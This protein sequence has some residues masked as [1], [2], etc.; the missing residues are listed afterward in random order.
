MEFHR[1]ADD[2]PG[3]LAQHIDRCAHL[4]R[5]LYYLA[6]QY[7]VRLGACAGLLVAL[8]APANAQ[9]T[10]DP[11]ITFVANTTI[12]S[13]Q[14]N[15]N[16]A[17]LYANFADALNRTGG[18]MTG[19]LL[20]NADNTLDLGSAALSWNDIWIDGTAT[21]ATMSVTTL[22]CT[23]CVGATQLASTTVTAAAYGSASGVGTF[24][25]DADGRLTAAST[26]AIAIAA[27]QITSGNY[28]ATLTA[29]SGV[30]VGTGTGTGSTPAVSLTALTADWTQS[31][32]YDIV[33]SNASAEI[34]IKESTGDTYYGILEVG[35]LSA[36]DATYTFSG[37]SGTVYTSANDPFDTS[38]EIQSVAVG[39]DA[40]GTVGNIAVAND[41][42]THDAGNLTGTTLA[43][44]VVSTSITSTGTISSGT[45]SASFGNASV[46]AVAGGTYTGDDSIATVGTITTGTWNAG[47][48]TSSGALTSSLASGTALSITN[49]SVYANATNNMLL[50][51][52]DTAP[53][54]GISLYV[55]Q[56]GVSDAVKYA[57]YFSNTSTNL[58]SNN[59]RYGIYVAST[60][61]TS[62]D[63]TA[64]GIY[65]TASGGTTANWAG[66]F[67]GNVTITG[68][69]NAVGTITSG[70]WNAGAVTSSGT[71]AGVS[72]TASG[73]MGLAATG[74]LYLDGV[75]MTGNTYI[76]EASAD[77]V[78]LVT[79][80]AIHLFTS[81][82]FAAA[83]YPTTA[84]PANV[85]LAGDGNYIT[86]VTSL[87]AAKDVIGPI[88]TEEARRVVMALSGV[89]YRSKLPND[90]RRIWP[91]FVAE[92][93]EAVT[94][95]LAMYGLDGTLQSVAYDRVAAYL[96][97]VAQD[98]DARLAALEQRLAVLEAR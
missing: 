71:I 56:I 37:T 6:L 78:Y 72:V 19:A 15:Y 48:V 11:M 9:I 46:S 39:G 85:Y 86:I 83:A 92:D 8:S 54:A 13:A 1:H 18:T 64:Y 77:T 82:G 98:H 40:S 25:V 70:V 12:Q 75:A 34:K 51:G 47:A 20:P 94:R 28:V 79:G 67:S 89:L 24:T 23:G 61:V 74:K 52:E 10:P 36:A 31:G 60:G 35:D 63:S 21:I 27:T 76:S 62:G 4:G 81:T 33:L 84:N 32:A 22:T 87:R 43:A 69:A 66:Y 59:D 53:V 14:V 68:T 38:G 73:N 2:H 90:D 17:E 45:W 93:V 50:V 55:S 91:G 80:A 88:P 95:D 97:P 58:T 42:H 29:G 30:A 57:G 3:R 96:V 41:S 5:Q 7:C 49:A 44:G 26:T 65:A 16:F